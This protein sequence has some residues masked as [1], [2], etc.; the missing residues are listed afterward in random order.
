MNEANER[1][2]YT[3]VRI[4]QKASLYSF[5]GK[6]ITGTVED[7]SLDGLYI[8][9]NDALNINEE[10]HLTIIFGDSANELHIECNGIIVRSD[11]NGMGIHF[12][13]IPLDKYNQ[14]KDLLLYNVESPEIIKKDF[15]E[16]PDYK[17]ID[18]LID[19]IK[20]HAKKTSKFIKDD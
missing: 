8:S 18:R 11:G 3:R 4:A 16:T 14:L 1:R 5:S 12:T 17:I 6:E 7:I 9:C 15:I 13:A 20:I 2:K 19:W 10:C